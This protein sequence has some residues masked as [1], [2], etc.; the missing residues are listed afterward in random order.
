MTDL[1]EA[2]LIVDDDKDI[3]Y[4]FKRNF[5]S[6]GCPLL[7][8]SS[9]EEA[10]KLVARKAP[11]IV[12]MD[13][14]M[15]GLGGLETL[16]R[17]HRSHPC[18]PVIIMTAYGTTQTAID[19]MKDG[20]FDYV[21][22]PFEV[23]RMQGLIEAALKASRDMN[24]RV[25]YQP[26]LQKE[27]YDQGI[28]GKSASMQEVYKRIGQVS[29][30]DV[31]V[32]ITGETGT[33]KELVARAIVQHGARAGRPFLAIN[34]AAIPENLLE[35]ELF[36]HEKGA[37][38]GATER[39]IGKFEQCDTGAIFLDEIGD[40]PLAVQA[41][42]LRVLQDG[43]IARVGSSQSMKVNVRFLAATHQDLDEMVRNKTFREDLFYRLNVVRIHLP[44]LRE[45]MEDLPLLIDYFLTRHVRKSD[46]PSKRISREALERLQAHPWPGNVRE[47]ENLILRAAVLSSSTAIG[48]QDLVLEEE[49][50][51]RS[52][53]AGAKR[54]TSDDLEEALDVL[55]RKA[56]S[57][58]KFKLIAATERMLVTRALALAKGNHVQ[59]AKLLGIT[60]AT[61]R[62]RI[63]KFGIRCEVKVK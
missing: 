27:E 8:A 52:T 50:S 14:R 32:M 5:D 3:H 61:L 12:V 44:P 6:L 36:G 43:E 45:R 13:V 25:S 39:R 46:G 37:F 22:K 40:M 20:A 55:F 19:A 51:C 49:T 10:L 26:L 24:E 33:G 53:P 54:K 48:A 47:L 7:F 35:S 21:I 15:A 9:G 30:S 11:A 62:K 16:K 60:R 59:A 34:C 28:V 17:L 23:P 42:L 57:D 31:P 63:E 18:L 41:K 2:I 4:S 29:S 38:T 1:T 58:P 56:A